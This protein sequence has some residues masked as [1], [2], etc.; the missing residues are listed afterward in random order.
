MFPPCLLQ[1]LVWSGW[2]MSHAQGQKTPSSS[3]SSP[4]GAKPTAGTSR[5]P[6]WPAS[7][8]PSG[9]RH[10]CSC[11]A[12]PKHCLKLKVLNA[13]PFAPG[14]P[15]KQ[16]VAYLPAKKK[17]KKC[18]LAWYMNLIC[19]L[20]RGLWLNVTVWATGLNQGAAF[21]NCTVW[22]EGRSH[23]RMLYEAELMGK[24]QH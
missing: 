6:V 5:T 3:V 1:V 18:Q 19:S 14:V 13:L 23:D 2:M 11:R 7:S 24:G 10:G 22:A 16:Y 15:Y 12:S 8:N 9:R 17:E 21:A 20:V 4:V